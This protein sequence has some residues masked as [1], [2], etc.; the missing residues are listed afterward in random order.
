MDQLVSFQNL[1]NQISKKQF[2]L[3]ILSFRKTPAAITP[4]YCAPE[5]FT[6][7]PPFDKVDLWALGIFI[8]EITYRFPPFSSVLEGNKVEITRDH[9]IISEKVRKG[10]LKFNNFRNADT[11]IENMKDLCRN[12][13]K[14]NVNERFTVKQAKAHAFFQGINWDALKSKKITEVSYCILLISIFYLL[15]DLFFLSSL[16]KRNYKQ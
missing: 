15:R 6:N 16:Q 8:Y 5:K 13:L 4:H 11:G 3:L 2:Y 7:T 14:V 9:S 10:E 1:R 12:L